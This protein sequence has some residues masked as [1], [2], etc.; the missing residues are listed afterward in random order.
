MSDS[1]ILFRHGLMAEFLKHK[2]TFLLWFV[3]AVPLAITAIICLLVWGDQS[4]QVND[5]WR[6]YIQ[7]NFTRY[8]QVFVFLQILFICHITYLEHRNNTWKNL[9][10][11]PVPFWVI[12][13]SKVAF[14][15]LVLVINVLSFYLFIMLSG[16]LLAY[17]RPDLGFG[18]TSYWYEALIP[19][20]KF[21]LASACVVCIM[22]MVSYYVK[23]ILT[24][25][26]IGFT[27]YASALALFLYTSREGYK[28][29]PY[30]TWHP[31]NFSGLA[32][33]SFGTGNH[34]LNIEYV[35][36][37]LVGGILVVALH[38]LLTRYKNVL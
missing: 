28:G 1:L 29:L 20:L 16:H 8:F 30:A 15:Y 6:W 32:F 34:L 31:F 26:V 5:P 17:L 7:F 4:M 36:Y 19:S 2:G 10:V 24:S 22:Y 14:G 21:I 11:L 38:Y 37:G 35:Y 23:S 18:D 27:G 33:S 9:R 25:I 3:M 13:F 12:F